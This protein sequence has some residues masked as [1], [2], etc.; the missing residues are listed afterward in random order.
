MQKSAVYI[1][2][3]FFC[4]ILGICFYPISASA[5]FTLKST[6]DLFSAFVSA[7]VSAFVLAVCLAVEQQEV[8]VWEVLSSS[9]A[10]DPDQLPKEP[11]EDR[12]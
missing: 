8:F 6:D 5:F 9:F 3:G 1:D 11:I 2:R 12:Q 10:Y 7:S 4:L